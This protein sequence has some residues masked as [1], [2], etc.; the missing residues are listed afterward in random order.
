MYAAGWVRVSGGAR[1]ASAPSGVQGRG[2]PADEGGP[3]APENRQ[4]V[5]V[6]AD[7]AADVLLLLLLLLLL[8]EEKVKE[9]EEDEEEEDKGRFRE[10]EE[11]QACGQTDRW[12][13]HNSA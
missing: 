13:E 4:A 7:A 3:A 10:I 5:R 11:E 6:T 12:R 8:L 1:C 2:Q 9:E